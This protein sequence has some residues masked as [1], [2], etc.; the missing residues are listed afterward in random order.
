MFG[1]AG[2]FA[3]VVNGGPLDLSRRDDTARRSNAIRR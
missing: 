3:D 1:E 2:L